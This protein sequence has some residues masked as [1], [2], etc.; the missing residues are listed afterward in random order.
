[1]ILGRDEQDIIRATYEGSLG[2]RSK[3]VLTSQQYS[4]QVEMLERLLE[5]DLEQA[6][7]WTSWDESR[8]E[9][10][11]SPISFFVGTA[12]TAAGLFS[13]GYAM[14]VLRG[15]ALMTVLASSLPAWRLIDP[16]ALLTAYRASAVGADDLEK[17]LD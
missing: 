17:M 6:I 10:E 9:A 16:A 2:S 5:L 4:A 13:V 12:G 8:N 3:L 11:K 15:G 1:V 7:V 14:W